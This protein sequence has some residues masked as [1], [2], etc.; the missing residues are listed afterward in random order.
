MV[1]VHRGLHHMS[2]LRSSSGKRIQTFSPTIP[3][4]KPK[5]PTSFTLYMST[6]QV[7]A[8]STTINSWPLYNSFPTRP[9]TQSQ[10]HQ[11][12]LMTRDTDNSLLLL[13]PLCINKKL[14]AVEGKAKLSGNEVK[15]II[16]AYQLKEKLLFHDDILTSL[17]VPIHG[18]MFAKDKC[19]FG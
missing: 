19:H 10:E 9:H 1:G 4:N 14:K 8:S 15:Q 17:T 5:S 12:D 6:S 16:T 11:N 7:T 18:I 3:P 2:P 13:T